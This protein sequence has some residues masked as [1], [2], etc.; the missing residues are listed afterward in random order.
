MQIIWEE[1][2]LDKFEKKIQGNVMKFDEKLFKFSEFEKKILTN[3]KQ[4]ESFKRLLFTLAN[5]LANQHMG[6]R[7][8]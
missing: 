1:T 2:I 3:Q 5:T 8:R 7:N 6:Y 4:E